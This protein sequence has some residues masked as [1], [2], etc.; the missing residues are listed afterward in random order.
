[1]S[2]CDNCKHLDYLEDSDSDGFINYKNSGYICKQ[3]VQY[4]NLKSFP[5]QKEMECFKEKAEA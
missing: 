4:Q 5:F 3:Y 1:M 2:N